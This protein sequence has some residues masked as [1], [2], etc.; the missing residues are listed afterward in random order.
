[1]IARADVNALAAEVFGDFRAFCGLLEIRLKDTGTRAFTYDTWFAE[2][3]QFEMERTGRDLVL[4]GRQIGFST[5]ELARDL[6][7]TLTHSGVQVLVVS[8]D[9]S[10]VER[11]FEDAR[12]WVDRLV[13]LRLIPKPRFSTKREL[14]WKFNRSTMRVVEAGKTKAAA[15]G[16]GRSGTI[17]RAH[18]TEVAFWGA[19]IDA[20]TAI[21]AA[22]PEGGEVV[23]ESTPNGAAGLFYDM[24]STALAGTGT[25]R[26]HFFPWWKHPEY[27][28]DP[29]PGF[30]PS[31]PTGDDGKPDIWE[32]KLR[33]LGC[34]DAQVAWWR[35]KV[36]DP[37][38]GG[39]E[40]VLQEYPIDAT[41]CFRMPGGSFLDARSCDWLATRV[42]E[43][44]ELVPIVVTHKV[45]GREVEKRLGRLVVFEHPKLGEEY[46]IGGDVAEG[47]EGDES[48][49]DV[50]VRRTGQTVATFASNTIDPGD[51][52]LVLAWTGLRYNRAL[53]APERN[54]HGHTTLRTLSNETTSVTPYRQVFDGHDGRP[55]WVTS[56]ATRP[57]LFDDLA[58]AV[59][60]RATSSPDQSFAAQSR[61]LVRGA[62][63]K[64]AAAGKGTKGGA[65]DDRWIARAIA[66]QLR[67]QTEPRRTG[68]RRERQRSEADQAGSLI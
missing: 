27:R 45:D 3:R 12:A 29:G 34:D 4:K 28:R 8:H 33:E 52:G 13:A 57:P 58:Q 2:Q 38:S 64:P 63:G 47:V 22:V 30:N 53:L 23:W 50:M 32:T 10:E 44:L 68:E 59:K 9:K 25:Y 55:G 17:H 5:E 48:A 6:F 35:A 24:C 20:A 41:S 7:Y 37:A 21:S 39:L 16:K 51:F 66:W 14:T 56:P 11:M 1:M 18:L 61:T 15:Q 65:R 42:R 49:L 60:D 54:N 40:R 67:Q 36:S 19:A 31:P 43:P 26:L 46:V 62:N